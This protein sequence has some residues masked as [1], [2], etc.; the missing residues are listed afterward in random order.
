[1]RQALLFLS[2]MAFFAW[3]PA[4]PTLAQDNLLKVYVADKIL[5]MDPGLP[6]ATAVAVLNG[7]IAAVGDLE[8]LTALTDR[9]PHEII[10]TFEDKVIVPG[11]IASHEHPIIAANTI[12]HRPLVAFYS[13]PN[14]FGTDISGVS[15]K[16]E[17]LQRL[18][19]AVARDPESTETI[20][21]WGMT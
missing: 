14:P 15:S 9:F 18:K 10:R 19:D 12:T 3:L 6:E 17:A 5:T 7:R 13:T 1:M 8:D 20:F 21:T 11:F 2:A 16:E 4:K